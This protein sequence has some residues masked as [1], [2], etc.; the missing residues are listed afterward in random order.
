MVK[1]I[2]KIEVQEILSRTIEIESYTAK[3]AREKVEEMY[4]NQEI[5][6]G[7]DDFKEKSIKIVLG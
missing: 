3:S 4:R 1:R 5:I 6:L 2:Y 7:G